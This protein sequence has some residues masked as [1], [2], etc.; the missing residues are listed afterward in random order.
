MKVAFTY[1]LRRNDSEEEAEFDSAETVEAIAAAIET[2][3]HEVEQIEVSS[4]A[5]TLLE[6]LDAADPDIVFNTAEGANG[7]MREAFYPAIFE[8]LG[9]PYT[10]SD[11]Y[12]MAVTLD[13]WLTKLVLRNHGIDTPR[14]KL[15]K[16]EQV[17]D[18]LDRGPGLAFPLIVKPNYEGSSKGIAENSV[19]N[20]LKE[21]GTLLRPALRAFPRW[22]FGRRIH[23]RYRRHRGI[24]QWRR[25]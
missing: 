17:Q 4:S 9:V 23:R 24:Y 14:S 8:Q 20:D 18:L 16:A 5:A 10:G 6:Q 13:K 3:G 1:N 25:S 11:A 15:A 7:R 2:A 21:L 22:R 12:T 19:A